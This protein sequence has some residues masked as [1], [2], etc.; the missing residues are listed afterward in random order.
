MPVRALADAEAAR[1]LTPAERA[2]VARLRLEA[3][4]THLELRL[5]GAAFEQARRERRPAADAD[6]SR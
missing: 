4:A 3:E 6:S 5:L 1:P 2:R